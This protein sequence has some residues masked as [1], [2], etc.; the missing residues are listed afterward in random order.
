MPA[1]LPC[2]CSRDGGVRSAASQSIREIPV[3]IVLLNDKLEAQIAYQYRTVDP[4][5]AQNA[6]NNFPGAYTGAGIVAGALGMAI[7][8]AIVNAGLRE[9]AEK[10][11]EAAYS[12]LQ[13]AAC[14][15]PPSAALA[16]T[17][18]RTVRASSWGSS[19]PV[20]KSLLDAN[21]SL[22]DVVDSKQER[23]VLTLSYSLTPDFATVITSLNE[24][25]YSPSIAGS[26]KRWQ[27]RPAWSN[28]LLAFSE[29]MQVPDKSAKDIED[30]VAAEN[31]R[32]ASTGAA[33]LISK[34]N[35]GDIR[36][37]KKA[38]ALVKTHERILSEARGEFWTTGQTAVWRSRNW[39]ANECALLVQALE[40]NRGELADMLTRLY[41]GTL[42][43]LAEEHSDPDSTLTVS[44]G[45]VPKEK[46]RAVVQ[47]SEGMYASRLAGDYSST[48]YLYSWYLP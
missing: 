42:P 26:P 40:R 16:D 35:A 23:H 31:A 17:V 8:D 45:I 21:K 46:T 15:L 18:E 38:V 44:V 12:H 41:D 11:V 43:A 25:V 20:H 7:G 14:R 28:Q 27:S 36:A 29:Y 33:A 32:Y 37:R 39:T 9:A 2:G 1:F 4:I 22:A 13:Q 10:E 24:N 34:A 6:M 48:V 5:F 3:H 47:E 19:V 30:A